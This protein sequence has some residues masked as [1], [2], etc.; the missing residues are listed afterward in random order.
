LPPA[1]VP[2]DPSSMLDSN[3]FLPGDVWRNDPKKATDTWATLIGVTLA[4]GQSE[5][6]KNSL[7]RIPTT[8]RYETECMTIDVGS[9][10]VELLRHYDLFDQYNARM[11][12][13]QFIESNAVVSGK[14]TSVNTTFSG[15]DWDH[16]SAGNNSQF[17]FYQ[18]FVGVNDQG[19]GP[20]PIYV[21][22]DH[23]GDYG[24]LAYQTTRTTIILNGVNKSGA[25]Q[26]GPS[27]PRP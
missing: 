12:G 1:P 19:L 10:S 6:A 20:F 11:P 27:D 21:S 24:V 15:D 8:I 25:R 23:G 16:I 2:Q 7:V 4:T 13:G 18:T 14:P 5:K 17:N 26:C 3:G 22:N 9:N